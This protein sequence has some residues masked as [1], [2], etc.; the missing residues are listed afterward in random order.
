[1][2]P[3]DVE[4]LKAAA[5]KHPDEFKPDLLKEGRV[6]AVPESS[7][8][9][10]GRQTIVY[11]QTIPG[12][13]EGVQV[14]LGPR[15]L[16][17]DNIPY[18]PVLEGIKADE[19]IVTAGSFLVD[20]ETR[21]N[22]AAGSI[23]FGGSSGSK[24]GSSTTSVRP[25]MPEDPDAKITAALA[26]LSNADRQ[27]AEQQRFCPI[28]STSRL[29]SMGVPIKLV[30]DDQPVFVCCAGCRKAALDGGAKTVKKVQ[31]LKEATKKAPAASPSPTK[32]SAEEEQEI[33][34][35]LAELTDEDRALALAQRF[36]ALLPDN[37]LGSMGKPEKIE[38]AGQSVFL[39]CD[40]C[41][42]DALAMPEKTLETVQR[43]KTARGNGTDSKGSP[44]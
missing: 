37:R 1:M 38:I 16:G 9:D 32:L 6:L 15:M 21:L 11:R 24:T 23:Y 30:I 3:K 42:E 13:Y 29:G 43:L 22:P 7:V 27:L 39:C 31:D 12:V 28:L 8:I 41:K 5:A 2:P 25:S 4:V 19:V 20:A 18:F 33:A 35:S 14:E 40:G 17:A 36:C 34:K 44:E 26:R 10:T